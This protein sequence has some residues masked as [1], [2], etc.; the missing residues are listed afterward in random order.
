MPNS[1]VNL[2]T[3][4]SKNTLKNS[5]PGVIVVFVI[6][7]FASVFYV[8]YENENSHQ[9]SIAHLTEK[10]DNTLSNFQQ[11][12]ENLAKNDLIINSIV[13]D[14]NRDNYLPIFFRSLKLN[15]SL[16]TSIVF[17]DYTGEIITGKN[18]ALHYEY[19]KHFNWQEQVLTNGLPYFEY[20]EV[21]IFAAAPVLLSTS[22]EGAIVSYIADLQDLIP[23]AESNLTL[24]YI[25]K[26]NKV[27]YSSNSHLIANG[28]IFQEKN[29]LFWSKNSQPYLSGNIISLEPPLHA[30]GNILWL[31]T[32][33][34]VSLIF[35]FLAVMTN[36]KSTA[37]YAS[38]SM[39][40]LQKTL[41]AA[42][43][44]QGQS[45]VIT[46]ND[47]EPIEFIAI[48]SEFETVLSHL[49]KQTISVQK[50]TSVINS[51]DEILLV[52]DEQ[53]NIILNNDSFT[54]F[55]HHI[56]ISIPQDI[57]NI[58]PNQSRF[59]SQGH[60]VNVEM[61]YSQHIQ[62]NGG[63]AIAVQWSA[64][65]Y[66]DDKG[67]VLGRI[68][69]GKDISLAK[70]LE[71][72]LLIKNQAIDSA[73]TSIII[74]DA[75]QNELPI[76]YAN[77][78][79]S[80]LT[81]YALHEVMGQNCRLLQGKNTKPEDIAK[82]K[83]AITK[84]EA[85]TATLTNYRKDGSEFQN[86]LTINPITNEHGVVTHFL[87]IQL[88]VTEREAA[89]KYLTLAKQKAEESTKLKSEFLASMS[90]E[91][92]TPMNGVIGML[93][94]LLMSK[95]TYEQH[96]NAEIA[97]D[98]AHSLLTIINDIL[99]FSK[100]ESGKLE[101]ENAAFD[102]NSLFS[103]VV[104]A[105][106]QQ[107]HNQNV[108]LIL[109]TC[110]IETSIVTGDSSRLRQVLNNLISNALKFTVQGNVTISA[111]I[112]P[113]NEYFVSLDCQVSDTGI[114]IAQN[115]LAHVFDSFTQADS[116]TTRLYGGTGLGLAITSKL[117]QLMNGA[118]SVTSEEGVGSCFSF[119]IQ[120]GLPKKSSA[121]TKVEN[122]LAFTLTEH[123][124][125]ILDQ[126][127]LSANNLKNQLTQWGAKVV[128]AD[129]K[130]NGSEQM[131]NGNFTIV[132]IDSAY[133]NG[134]DSNN[135]KSCAIDLV[136]QLS[137]QD[138]SQI[139]FILM[140]SVNENQDQDFI[141]AAGF[142]SFFSK[143]ATAE[144]LKFVLSE[145]FN[146]SPVAKLAIV[147]DSKKTTNQTTEKAKILLV[148]DNRINQLVAKKILLELGIE[149][150]IADNGQ[151]A[152]DILKS[153][154]TAFELIFMDCQMPILDGYQATEQIRAGLASE[155]NSSLPIIAMT[156]NAMKGDREK[157]L[158]HGMDD[159]ISK[160]INIETI[161][162]KILQW[163][164]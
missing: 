19:G 26:N 136:E 114:G 111:Q 75:E 113:Y 46:E 163:L 135:D 66:I 143:P 140:T 153:S 141:R 109:D 58:L 156:A 85:L 65:D 68:F 2:E 12:V 92:R 59:N 158:L 35:I 98:S 31:A 21:G 120:L 9:E 94:L 104:K 55:C 80:K 138:K 100:I 6:L 125:L 108:E 151:A 150:T 86:E 71:V 5:L 36:V 37:K 78:A 146:I 38:H 40:E 14:T 107:A 45:V 27:L 159:Y 139:A 106:A 25:N 82:I 133:T 128:I 50:F 7:F 117:C 10:L 127:T 155:Q 148:E 144:T 16:N 42:I 47:N 17:T 56:G 11:Q 97:K 110:A 63:E 73:E 142:R 161:R 74:T 87:G 164:K 44:K 57:S 53:Q 83:T 77:K 99:D 90:H 137:T 131:N 102:L 61:S 79:F 116:S 126:A 105:H 49:F 28:S 123:N 145:V 95:L 62:N 103:H 152:I 64:S 130:A 132:F 112:Q 81:G 1:S 84:Q 76:I 115:R 101:F 29:L 15:N 22:P 122:S 124:I 88:D 30:Y 13:D 162:D 93:D 160:P 48:R 147:D 51:L 69:V 121:I 149:V 32:I 33:I 23:V 89:A 41:A 8:V 154:Q 157:C 4:I 18:P 134:E 43:T 3:L 118:V 24:I 129:N 70:K 54:V 52:L 20:S 39:Q 72:E 60:N 34:I 67:D 119:N 91:I 96:H